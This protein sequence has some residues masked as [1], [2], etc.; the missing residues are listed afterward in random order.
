MI[1]VR[2]SLGLA[3][4]LITFSSVI[5]QQDREQR[6]LSKGVTGLASYFYPVA[7]KLFYQPAAVGNHCGHPDNCPIHHCR[8]DDTVILGFCCGCARVSDS[9]PVRCPPFLTCPPTPQPLCSQYD[10]MM[11]CCC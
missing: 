2:S 1:S 7:S 9:V 4:I 8:V 10:W 3:L 5:A 6:F 11:D